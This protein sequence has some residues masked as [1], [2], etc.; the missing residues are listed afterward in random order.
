M[1]IP[2]RKPRPAPRTRPG[3]RRRAFSLRDLAL[4]FGLVAIV[5]CG[6]GVT[7][8][9]AVG[10]A[11]DVPAAALALAGA[12]IVAA[13]LAHAGRRR[14]GRA[15]RVADPEREPA[16][17]VDP[18]GAAAC[19]DY[20]AMDPDTFEHSVAALCVRDGCLGVEVVGGAGDLGADVVATAPDGRRVV[21]Q[22]KAYGPDHKVGSQDVQRFGGTC[23]AVHD[24]QVA[25]VVTASEF[26]EPAAEYAAQC[27]ILCVDR[28]ALD[29]WTQ[30]TGPAPWLH[31]PLPT[32]PH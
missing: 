2:G 14:A 4:G 22:C 24:A 8:R 26:T 10:D 13:A 25:A 7:A 1:A 18:A 15:D 31:A 3:D 21:I 29:A 28:S 11:S 12:L 20:A 5:L 9:A 19:Q 32:E 17:V 6:T 16:L 23:F 27:G 30:G